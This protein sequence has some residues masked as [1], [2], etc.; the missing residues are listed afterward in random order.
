MIYAFGIW[1]LM[2]AAGLYTRLRTL[3]GASRRMDLFL[4]VIWPF[5]WGLQIPDKAEN[6]SI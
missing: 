3:H 4:S 6:R 5:C 2:V 1:Y